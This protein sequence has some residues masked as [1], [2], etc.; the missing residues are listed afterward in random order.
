MK[1]LDSIGRDSPDDDALLQA[2]AKRFGM[3]VIDVSEASIPDDVIKMLSADTASRHGV[4][5]VRR[6]GEVL[7]VAVGDPMA[8]DTL[9]SLRHILNIPVEAVYCQRVKLRKAIGRYY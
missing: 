3:E 4:L 9:D 7:T 8:T 2:L 1:D 5:P 6:T